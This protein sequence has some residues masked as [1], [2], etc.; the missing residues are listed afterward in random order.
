[1]SYVIV[2]IAQVDE[3]LGG[4][5]IFVYGPYRSRSV[6]LGEVKKMRDDD[7]LHYPDGPPVRFMV[8]KILTTP[9]VT[10]EDKSDELQNDKSEIDHTQPK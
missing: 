9:P 5:R 2:T 1:M 4:E 8:R 3:Q 7:E 10:K 6:G